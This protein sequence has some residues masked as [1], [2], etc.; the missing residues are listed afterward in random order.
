[1]RLG[2]GPL[3][4][5]GA[6]AA[7]LQDSLVMTAQQILDFY[8]RPA[9]MTSGCGHAPMFDELP[10]DVAALARVVTARLGQEPRD[11][12]PTWPRVR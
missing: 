5:A 1:M 6:H 9:E 2:G 12:L 8:T 4:S 7:P 10:R 11:G 3:V